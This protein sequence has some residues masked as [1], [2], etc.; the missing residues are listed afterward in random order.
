[1]MPILTCKKVK[2]DIYCEVDGVLWYLVEGDQELDNGH[3]RGRSWKRSASE[4]V[5]RGETAIQAAK[6]CMEEELGLVFTPE[7]EPA[8][9]IYQRY[10]ARPRPSNSFPGTYVQG[11]RTKVVTIL[12]PSLFCPEGYDEIKDGK[13]RTHFHWERAHDVWEIT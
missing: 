5:K 1:L 13:V 9:Y 11:P 6:R 2:I 10:K 7:T 8:F 3:I 4:K 12:H